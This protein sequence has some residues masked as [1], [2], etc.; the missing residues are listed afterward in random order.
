MDTSRAVFP[1]WARLLLFVGLVVVAAYALPVSAATVEA[2]SARAENW[3]VVVY[4]ALVA[5]VGAGVGAF[6]PKSSRANTRA[7]S[8]MGRRRAPRGVH[9]LLRLVAAPRRLNGSRAVH[10]VGARLPALGERLLFGGCILVGTGG[11]A[12][13][14][15]GLTV[16]VGR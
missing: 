6:V 2:I 16:M 12:S 9:R 3:I 10:L 5:L 11:R 15:K 1:L 8:A 7:R 13:G 14:G 4:C